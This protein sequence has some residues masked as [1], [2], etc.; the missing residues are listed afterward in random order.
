MVRFTKGEY[1][2]PVSAQRY[3]EQAALWGPDEDRPILLGATMDLDELAV[4]GEVATDRRSLSGI[5]TGGK[6]KP[7]F[8]PV[9]ERPPR[10]R[11]ASR[12]AAVGLL[13]RVID[14]LNRLSLV[15]RGSVPGGSAARSFLLQRDHLAPDKPTYHA[16]VLRD[17]PWIICQYW[18][19]Y[20]FNNWRSGFG[21][22]NE[23]E[24]D[25]EQVTVYLDG[26]GVLDADGLPPARWVVFSAHDETGDDL[27]R[28]WDD[29]DLG[30]VGGR[31]PIVYAG[32]GS[33]SGAYLPG[34]YLITVPTPTLRG[35]VS[36][37]RAVG[38]FLVPWSR[39]SAD[40]GIGIPYID[41]ARGDGRVIGPGGDPWHPVVIDDDTAWVRDYRGLWGHDTNDRLG[42]ERGPAGPRY[43]RSGKVRESWADPVGWAGMAKVAPNP[44]AAAD[45]LQRRTDQIEQQLEALTAEVESGRLAL[46]EAAAGLSPG[47]PAIRRLQPEEE[48]LLDLRMQATALADELARIQVGAAPAGPHDHLRHRRVPLTMQRGLRQR[49]LAVWAVISTPVI[50]YVLAAILW[51]QSGTSATNI[52]VVWLVIL[53]SIEGLARGKFLAVLVRMAVAAAVVVALYFFFADW[54]SVLAGVLFAASLSLLIVNIRDAWKR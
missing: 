33:H 48:R 54:R 30:L 52:T 16:R 46:Q 11:G 37:L 15:F 12:L 43:E 22:V 34:D 45:L 47:N 13:A 2:F 35:L 53:L 31:H 44:Q 3:V 41:Y 18:F 21:G 9:T 38:R 19:F 28:R 42:G 24:A 26:T 20:C 29:P 51:P 14:A 6:S 25:W 4:Q 7:A 27:R 40:E 36:V 8:I 1:F 23:H 50:L 5:M 32:A 10:M 39:S 49:V 17:G